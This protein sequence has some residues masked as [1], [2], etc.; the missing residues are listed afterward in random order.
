M[1][2]QSSNLLVL[3]LLALVLAVAA[4]LLPNPLPYGLSLQSSATEV[5]QVMGT[6]D[7]SSY[8]LIAQHILNNF[9]F[10]SK[11]LA[12]WPPGM[13]LLIALQLKLFG[14]SNY[15]THM[16]MFYLLFWTIALFMLFQTL[17]FVRN[18][19]LRF[20]LL[21]GFCLLPQ[22][23]EWMVGGKGLLHSDSIGNALFF[24]GLS[25]LLGALRESRR[26]YLWAATG[27][28]IAADYV[29]AVFDFSLLCILG[30]LLATG[31]A[32]IAG[33][34]FVSHLRKPSNLT[35]AVFQ[36][37]W[38]THSSAGERQQ[39]FSLFLCFLVFYFCTGLWKLRE[40]RKHTVY[41]M[42]A[43]QELVWMNHWTPSEK[44][45]EHL[46]SGNTACMV[47]PGLCRMVDATTNEYMHHKIGKRLAIAT[48]FDEP[49]VWLKLRARDFKTLWFDFNKDSESFSV[50]NLLE[51]SIALFA[52][53]FA[54]FF[55]LVFIFR[56]G[57]FSLIGTAWVVLAY[58]LS[59]MAIFTFAHFEYRYS[60]PLRFFCLLSPLWL[61]GVKRG[62]GKKESPS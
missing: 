21:A 14:E 22:I 8:I 25:F 39:L 24:S 48:F 62:N 54:F 57:D 26:N 20:A 34:I 40:H 31:V 5:R 6:S 58:L 3:S 45:K 27:F 51:G 13:P 61:L 46:V 59:N 23:R 56:S 15:L 30:G 53:L 33:A 10:D 11:L 28:F 43:C 29:R 42:T 36:K 18:R 50:I 17:T 41:G 37:K 7:A 1:P 2:R 60:F 32:R 16:L 52:G 4:F 49:W 35:L 55:A 12:C 19:Y 9:D 47:S 44:L 38:K